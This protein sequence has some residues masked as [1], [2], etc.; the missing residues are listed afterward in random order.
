MA[1][2]CQAA[3][4]MPLAE[5]W[6]EIPR[7]CLGETCL[8]AV[9]QNAEFRKLQF[10]VQQIFYLVNW[11]RTECR[12]EISIGFLMRTF[13]CFCCAVRSALENGLN[14]PKSRGHHLAVDPGSDANILAW[15]KKQA[16]KKFGSN[17]HR[18]QELLL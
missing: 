17:T 18:Y 13:N 5:L 16:E 12:T 7:N 10:R 2:P 4:A 8:F 11:A 3:P 9:Q 1:K 6:R 15:I 14:P